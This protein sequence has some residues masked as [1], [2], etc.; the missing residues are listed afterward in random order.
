MANSKGSKPI[1]ESYRPASNRR[2]DFKGGSYQPAGGNE[3]T[4]RSYQ[5]GHV[6]SGGRTPPTGGT[7]TTSGGGNAGGES[8]GTSGNT[9]GSS[10]KN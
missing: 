8:S 5:V 2:S 1:T 3:G 10:D 4:G 6:G 9:S 7:G